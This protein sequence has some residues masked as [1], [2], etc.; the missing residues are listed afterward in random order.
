M[1]VFGS[2]VPPKQGY[3]SHKHFNDYAIT[4]KGDDKYPELITF[5]SN[6]IIELINW[7]E[8]VHDQLTPIPV[9]DFTPQEVEWSPVMECSVHRP[10]GQFS[11]N[12]ALSVRLIISI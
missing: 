9:A 8:N 1:W 10:L 12:V 3:F 5:Y 6:V 7:R 11:L 2:K 4:Q